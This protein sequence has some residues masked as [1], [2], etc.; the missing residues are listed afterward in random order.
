[1]DPK[2]K[3][4]ALR[5]ITYGLYVLTVRKGDDIGAAS[6]NWL[7]QASFEPP[8]IVAAVKADSDSHRLILDTGTF[9]VNVLGEDQLDIGRAFFRRTRLEDGKLNGYAFEDGEATGNPILLDVPYWWEARVNDTVARGDHTVFVATV[10]GAG[11]RNAEAVPLN[12]RATGMNY[13]G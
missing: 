3:K 11:V 2:Q 7:T 4:T 5:S 13:G 12:L 9:A 6:I 8:L 1:M 10:V